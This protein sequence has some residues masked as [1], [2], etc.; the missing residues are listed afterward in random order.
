MTDGQAKVIFQP[1]Q[2]C[3]GNG[4]GSI[5]VFTECGHKPPHAYRY[6]SRDDPYITRFADFPR[7]LIGRVVDHAGSD[8]L[9][10]YRV[11]PVLPGQMRCSTRTAE[12]RA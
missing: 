11:A 2:T 1:G 6:R 12:R 3:L 9:T 5:I 7:P 4:N 10:Q 8:R